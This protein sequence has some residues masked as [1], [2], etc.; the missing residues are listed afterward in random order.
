MA[1]KAILHNN[2]MNVQGKLWYK[3]KSENRWGNQE[4][5]IQRH[6]QHW[7]I[8]LFSGLR[9]EYSQMNFERIILNLHIFPELAR[10]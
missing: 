1:L 8:I 7:D 2:L 6:W 3:M 10:L 4:S 9:G 5:T